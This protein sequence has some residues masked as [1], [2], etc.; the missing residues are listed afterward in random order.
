MWKPV[1][2]ATSLSIISGALYLVLYVLAFLWP[3]GFRFLFNAQFFGADVASLLPREFSYADFV[4]TL[5]AVVVSVWV[6]AYAWAA[7]Y[8][9]LAR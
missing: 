6:V 7:L 5:I 1:P 3:Q 4:G 2:F 8:N 9:R